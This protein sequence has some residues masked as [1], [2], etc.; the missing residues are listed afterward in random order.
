M[1][2]MEPTPIDPGPYKPAVSAFLRCHLLR[3]RRTPS[4][5]PARHRGADLLDI[6]YPASN[7]PICPGCPMVPGVPDHAM[8]YPACEV[9]RWPAVGLGQVHAWHCR[10][11][12]HWNEHGS[13]RP[14]SAAVVL[15]LSRVSRPARE[16]V[17]LAIPLVFGYST[18]QNVEVWRDA[19]G[20]TQGAAVRGFVESRR[21]RR[22]ERPLYVRGTVRRHP[23]LLVGGDGSDPYPL[24]LAEHWAELRSVGRWV[25]RVACPC[26]QEPPCIHAQALYAQVVGVIEG[27]RRR[28][29]PRTSSTW[30]STS[31]HERSP[32]SSPPSTHASVHLLVGPDSLPRVSANAVRGAQLAIDETIFLHVEAEH[33]TFSFDHTATFTVS[34]PRGAIDRLLLLLRAA[35]ASIPPSNPTGEAGDRGADPDAH[36]PAD[37]DGPGPAGPGPDPSRN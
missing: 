15:Q 14:R 34:G 33:R 10:F 13:A 32:S 28:R 3:A 17:A 26:G 27:R 19:A 4:P 31:M 5:R 16:L 18:P 24:G 8:R 20:N 7:S 1:P 11:C 9:C 35:V 36:G 2:E 23:V 29:N 30:R 12:R 6:L 25:T 22:S 21:L 37:P